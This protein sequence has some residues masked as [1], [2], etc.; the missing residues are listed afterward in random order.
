M[1][2]P[3]TNILLY[4]TNADCEEH[5]WARPVLEQMLSEP[6]EWIVA[7]QVLLEYYRLLRN[8]K[9]L[10]SPLSGRDAAEQLRFFRDLSGCYHCG[11]EI[12]LW[13]EVIALLDDDHFAPA[14]TFDAV[15]AVTLRAAGV[16][17]LFTRNEKDFD[18]LGWFDV[19]NPEP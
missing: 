10:A 14:R 16:K 7:D 15:L 4:G 1:K 8:P 12:S 13:P 18:A 19:M 3:D 6:G 17:K 2:S 9:V 5:A 11:Y